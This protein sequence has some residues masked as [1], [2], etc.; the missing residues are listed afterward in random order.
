[1][2]QVKQPGWYDFYLVIREMMPEFE[3]QIFDQH[4][5]TEWEQKA[6]YFNKYKLEQIQ[7][8][9]KKY[10]ETKKITAGDL[11]I[12]KLELAEEGY[13]WLGKKTKEEAIAFVLNN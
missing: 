4:K 6:R 12:L 1:M 13:R 2:K 8:L 9:A 11:F 5:N 7:K 10:K 3:F